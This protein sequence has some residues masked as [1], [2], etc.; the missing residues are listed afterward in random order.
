MRV[1]YPG[2]LSTLSLAPINAACVRALKRRAGPA[3]DYRLMAYGAKAGSP[4]APLARKKLK[5]S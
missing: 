4:T 3:P 5:T 1:P 2:W